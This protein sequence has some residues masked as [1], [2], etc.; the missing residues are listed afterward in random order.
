MSTKYRESRLKIFLSSTMKELRDAR[1]IVDRELDKR[2]INAWVYENNVS[3][4]PDSVVATSLRQVDGADVYVG[5]F[6][7]LHGKVTIEEF[8]QARLTGKPCFVYI[9]EKDCRRDDNLETFLQKEIYDLQKGVTYRFFERVSE[10]G[11]QIAEDI[12][13]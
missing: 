4:A 13:A 9:R 11:E 1:D 7:Q 8:Q 10:L 3:A 6:W 2:G 5:L 12:L